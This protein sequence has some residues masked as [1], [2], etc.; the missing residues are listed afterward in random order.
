[1]IYFSFCSLNPNRAFDRLSPIQQSSMDKYNLMR[2][3][4]MAWAI[5]ETIKPL[6]NG[7]GS[8]ITIYRMRND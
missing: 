3:F 5:F 6:L 4:A 2:L 8:S 1:M 7:S